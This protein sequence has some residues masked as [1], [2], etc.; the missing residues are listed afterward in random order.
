[1]LVSVPSAH[2]IP[3]CKLILPP[4]TIPSFEFILIHVKIVH[5]ASGCGMFTHAHVIIQKQLIN[6]GCTKIQS[7][8]QSELCT[9][10]CIGFVA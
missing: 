6:H 8:R 4:T 9:L 5:H 7:T 10:G 2:L 1:M 3:V